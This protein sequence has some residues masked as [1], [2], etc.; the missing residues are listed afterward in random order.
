MMK[1]ENQKNAQRDWIGLSTG[2][3][4]EQYG[5][6]PPELDPANNNIRLFFISLNHSAFTHSFSLWKY[7]PRHAICTIVYFLV[8]LSLLRTGCVQQSTTISVRWSI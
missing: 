8:Q 7:Y 1:D 6:G 2:V 4:I 3:I 5:G